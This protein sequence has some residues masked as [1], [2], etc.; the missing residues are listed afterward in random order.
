MNRIGVSAAACAMLALAGC[1]DG[2]GRVD[3][4]RTGALGALIGAGV[5]TAGGAIA[6]SGQDKPY[7]QPRYSRRQAGYDGYGYSHRPSYRSHGYGYRHGLP[8]V[9]HGGW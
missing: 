5:F 3:P 8:P 7:R 2:R 1:E 6:K 9:T 4:L